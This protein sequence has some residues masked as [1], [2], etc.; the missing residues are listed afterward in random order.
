MGAAV[1]KVRILR[2]PPEYLSAFLP[3]RG[4]VKGS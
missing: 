4:T 1:A 3:M 2:Q